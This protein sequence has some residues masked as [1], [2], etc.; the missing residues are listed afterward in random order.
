MSFIELI[1]PRMRRPD[2]KIRSQIQFPEEQKLSELNRQ[3]ALNAIIGSTAIGN[4]QQ[5]VRDGRRKL[6]EAIVAFNQ[7]KLDYENE[8][9]RFLQEH[10]REIRA[11][12]KKIKELGKTIEDYKAL[13]FRSAEK[14]QKNKKQR[15]EKG[16]VLK[17]VMD[18]RIYE[19][20]KTAA[21]LN[22][23]AKRY[24]IDWTELPEE[25]QTKDG[26]YSAEN[27]SQVPYDFEKYIPQDFK[28]DQDIVDTPM[29]VES[30]IEEDG[31]RANTGDIENG[32]S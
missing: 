3:G 17:D 19:A 30:V 24:K 32:G 14:I 31:D 6:E 27:I 2:G 25:L 10:T 28:F 23:T 21:R 11:K 20:T 7:E 16:T 5:R 4:G 12:E 9:R 29:A 13:L 26:K 22:W 15:G 18:M 1:N 8:K